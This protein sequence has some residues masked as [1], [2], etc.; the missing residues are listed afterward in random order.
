MPIGGNK[1]Q[2]SFDPND[3]EDRPLPKGAYNLDALGADA[4]GGAP[5]TKP[6]KEVPSNL[7]KK[8]T[9]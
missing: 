5:D 6:K 9:A 8:A 4:F 7:A 3:T 2:V 1:P